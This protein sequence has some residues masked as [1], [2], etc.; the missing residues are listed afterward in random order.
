[1]IGNRVDIYLRIYRKFQD[2][3]AD[4][5]GI[6]KALSTFCFIINCLINDYTINKDI[7]N[8]YFAIKKEDYQKR[9][10]KP[11]LPFNIYNLEKKKE[12][13]IIINWTSIST[14]KRGKI[15]ENL[16]IND[17]SNKILK[18]DFTTN[19]NN[20]I[21]EKKKILQLQISSYF[22]FMK[23]SFLNGKKI[24]INN[25]KKNN[26]N[27]KLYFKNLIEKKVILQKK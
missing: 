15:I 27:F 8:H 14:S 19:S 4:I 17:K 6:S 9:K 21:N 25:S 10:Y 22:D 16:N 12:E 7:N 11:F 5:G 13:G 1:M 26:I 18:N 2:A 3:L 20:N 23:D 24:E